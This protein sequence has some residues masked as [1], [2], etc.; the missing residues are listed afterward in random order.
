[1]TNQQQQ[2]LHRL[3]LRR[4]KT[5]QLKSRISEGRGRKLK[6][7]E[8]PELPALLEF[9]FGDGD[10]LQRSGGGL[11]AHSKL[12][13]ET[14]YKASDNMTVMRE[15]LDLVRSL[16]PEDFKISLSCLY[17]YTMNYKQ[18][19]AQAKRHHCGTNVNA[20]IS[21]HTA[22][23]T[24]EIKKPVNAHWTS[25][26]V[27]F[28]C[29][30]AHQN[31]NSYLLDSRDAK[32]IVVGDIPPVLK[33]GRL[34]KREVYPDH[35]FDQSRN[36]AVTPVSHLLVETKITAPLHLSE[37]CFSIP[38]TSA[39]ILVTRT[40]KAMTIVNLSFYEPETVLRVFNDIFLLMSHSELA[41]LFR[42]PTTGQL[43][44][45]FNF[46]VDNGPSEAPANL[47]VQML[48][49]R[50]LK[51]LNLDKATQRSFAEYL[52]KRNFVERVHAVENTALS[53]H[54]VF[55]AHKIHKHADV[56][57]PQH[58]ENMEA[59]AE[60]VVDSLKRTTSGGKPIYPLRGSGNTL[61]FD[62]EIQLKEFVQLTDQR[63][64]QCQEDYYPKK[65]KVFHYL[66]KNWGVNEHFKGSYA[67]DYATLTN[68][69]TATRDHYS[70][71]VFREDE[72]WRGK[73]LERYEKRPVPYLTAWQQN[74]KLHY[75]PFELCSSLLHGPW[76]EL[77]ELFL[78]SRVLDLA[79][80]VF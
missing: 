35:T 31:P 48:L 3:V 58:K 42:N 67:D 27:N 72:S 4:L 33:P 10:R 32:C 66:V 47:Q 6:C 38:N 24:G 29:D 8:F 60:D 21:L 34:W 70:V 2:K 15:A 26:Y 55:D 20:R 75:L 9:A 14:M 61:V 39:S 56:G 54:G 63:K 64:V 18:G 74:G 7:E 50:L 17:T 12:Y 30:V 65:N 25:S 71:S 49:V 69:H 76:D 43:K 22:P 51:F 37:G 41:E 78:P 36:N 23:S 59:M 77:P 44:E 11:E 57:S 40:G 62:D 1:M 45:V 19:T 73:P 53:R 13:D 16:A 79:F 46:V 52:S 68:A 28:L 80:R 5:K